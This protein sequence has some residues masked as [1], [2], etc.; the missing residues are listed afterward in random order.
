[1]RKTAREGRTSEKFSMAQA[2]RQV[3]H[4]EQFS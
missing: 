1:M 2:K 3:L 4:P